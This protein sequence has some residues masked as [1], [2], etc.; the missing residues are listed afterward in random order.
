MAFRIIEVGHVSSIQKQIPR[1]QIVSKIYP[2]R[3][4]SSSV[5]LRLSLLDPFFNHVFESLHLALLLHYLQRS[6][7]CNVSLTKV[8]KTI[9]LFEK[10]NYDYSIRV[11]NSSSIDAFGV[12]TS[13]A[14]FTKQPTLYLDV[15]N[16]LHGNGKHHHDHDDNGNNNK[17]LVKKAEQLLA[18]DLKVNV[19][20]NHTWYLAKQQRPHFNSVLCLLKKMIKHLFIQL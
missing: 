11:A 3:Q 20:L 13:S 15:L 5:L 19:K 7:N 6:I 1:S 4:G 8:K 10:Q 14:P 2:L 12:E 17:N 16:D 9:T 18:A